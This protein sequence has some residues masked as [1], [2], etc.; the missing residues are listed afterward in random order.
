MIRC[1]VTDGTFALNQARW[2]A[3]M[4]HWIA[5][6]VELVQIRERGLPIR[7]LAELTRRVLQIPNLHGT[8]ILVNDRADVAI[9]CKAHGVHLRDGSVPLENFA[10]PG[11]LVT[12]SCHRIEDAAKTAGA[13]FVLLAPIFKP[14]SKMDHRPVLGTGAITEFTR[15]SSTPVLALGGVDYQNA[16]ACMDAGAAGIAG[17]TWFAR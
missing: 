1:L 7:D 9:A 5:E 10:R 15:R 14:L 6:G 13:G 11:F 4:A 8:K 17:I 12:V 16:Q 2:M 3:H